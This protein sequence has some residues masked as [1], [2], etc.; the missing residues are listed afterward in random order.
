MKV[1]AVI[2]LFLTMIAGYMYATGQLRIS[3]GSVVYVAPPSHEDEY[4]HRGHEHERSYCRTALRC[5]AAIAEEHQELIGPND[6]RP[7]L[8]AV[9][10]DGVQVV[11]DYYL[12]LT[13]DEFETAISPPDQW[14]QGN[15]DDYCA[16]E[17]NR[18]MTELG[19]ITIMRFY[20]SDK[21]LLGQ[22]RVDRCIG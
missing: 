20:G 7:E 1:L 6:D 13:K 19:V 4:G 15:K 12:P 8:R 10:A 18:P 5:A 14:L 21:L 3:D 11:Y 17:L 2:I 22:V 9:R 16:D